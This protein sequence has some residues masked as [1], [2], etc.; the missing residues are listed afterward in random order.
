MN[1]SGQAA[2]QYDALGAAY[3]TNSDAN[4]FNAHY[5]RPA[6]KALL[7]SVTDKRVLDVGCA[8]GSLTYWLLRQGAEVSAFDVS[9]EM[10]RL[11]RERVGPESDV[12]VAD[13]SEPL[14]FVAD[15]SIDIVVA[16]L[17]MHY[18][19]DWVPV[20]REFRR[21][22]APAGF[23]VFSTHHPTMDWQLH[24]P[25][26]Y[27]A[28]KQV[29]E[30]WAVG[31]ESFPVTFWRRPLTAMSEAIAEAGL[32]IERLV[33]PMPDE[34]VAAMSPRDDERLRTR[35]AFLFFRLRDLL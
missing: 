22:L 6:I 34:H 3:A 24:S 32:A 4:T 35:P 26:D 5:E 25:D 11:T 31:G 29:T 27:F 10:V 1:D 15:R 12:R 17:V 33:E 28:I 20:L 30:Y 13:V 19:R 18:L 16:S 9:P 21:V 7:G 8:A 2:V 23:I 14:D